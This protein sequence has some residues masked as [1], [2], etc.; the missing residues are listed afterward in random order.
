MTLHIRVRF[1]HL[2]L[3]M[4]QPFYP[5]FF[6]GLN[7]GNFDSRILLFNCQKK[8]EGIQN[9]ECAAKVTLCLISGRAAEI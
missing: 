3:K 4:Q 1:G 7:K 2:I 6:Q 5:L 8:S 9:N